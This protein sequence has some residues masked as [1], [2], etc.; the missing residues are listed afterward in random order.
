[1]SLTDLV[2][3]G[4]VLP[5]PLPLP[6]RSVRVVERNLQVYR[7][8][9]GMF[10]AGLA[11]PFFYLTGIGFGVGSLVGSVQ[12]G[13]H[14]LPYPVFVAPAL[15]ASAAMN[16]A[17]FDS[18][19]GLFFKLKIAK[20]YE[21]VLATPLGVGDIAAGEVLWALA[22]GAVYGA[23]FLLV[24]VGFGLVASP[25]AALALPGSILIGFAFASMGCAATSFA[26][27]WQDFDLILLVQMPIFLFSAT[28]F[29]ATVY[30]GPIRIIAEISPLTRGVDLL[31]GLTTGDLSPLMVL[32]AAYLLA[33]GLVGVAIT[34]RRLGR[35]LLK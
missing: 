4:R 6:L 35:V 18:T 27:N 30:P 21:A 10:V 29:P 24:M 22:R 23:A 13:S 5:A 34:S 2:R 33:I 28:F 12:V 17:Y 8:L 16:G 19:F 25:W 14:T 3:M 15:M 31:R 7:R 20:S 26:R 11:E 9:W 32:D 1:M